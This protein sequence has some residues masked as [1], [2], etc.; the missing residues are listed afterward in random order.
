MF[1]GERL[2]GMLKKG[3][4]KYKKFIDCR[5]RKKENFYWKLGKKNMCVID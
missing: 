4:K 2:G 5:K 1:K 3:Y